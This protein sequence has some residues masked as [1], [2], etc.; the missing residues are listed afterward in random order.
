VDAQA[1]D[2]PVACASWRPTPASG[3]GWQGRL[4]AQAAKLTLLIEGFQRTDQLPPETQADLRAQIGW[5]QDQEELLKQSGVTD[6]WF[7]LGRRI[8]E[9]SSGPLGRASYLKTQRTWLLGQETR[10]PALLL[11]FAAPSQVLDTSFFPDLMANAIQRV[12]LN[13]WVACRD[14]VTALGK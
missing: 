7:V 11:S 2:W 1:P 12:D 9:E 8:V 3:E 5:N 4:L 10:H 14:I 13:Q 6:G